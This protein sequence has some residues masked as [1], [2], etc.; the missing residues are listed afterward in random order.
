MPEKRAS[1]KPPQAASARTVGRAELVLNAIERE[2][3]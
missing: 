3:R 2:R 1:T